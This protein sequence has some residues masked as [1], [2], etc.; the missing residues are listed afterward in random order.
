[1]SV[2][3]NGHAIGDF[4]NGEDQRNEESNPPLAGKLKGGLFFMV[5]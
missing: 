5:K 1:V 4:L 3:P 2:T